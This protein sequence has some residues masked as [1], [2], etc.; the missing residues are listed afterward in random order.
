MC[1]CI[2]IYMYAC[3]YIH[4]CVH[5]YGVTYTALISV[6]NAS[7]YGVATISRLLKIIGL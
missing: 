2:Y 7:P 1:V 6:A 3:I 5:I 4:V